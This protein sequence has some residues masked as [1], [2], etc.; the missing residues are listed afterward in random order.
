MI[1]HAVGAEKVVSGSGL[2]AAAVTMAELCGTAFAEAVVIE[3]F[4]PN[5]QMGFLDPK[6]E[7]FVADGPKF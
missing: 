4:S 6:R 1:T 7:Y 5:I 3:N 2:H